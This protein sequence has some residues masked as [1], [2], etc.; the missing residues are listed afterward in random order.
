MALLGMPL[1]AEES[2]QCPEF[3]REYVEEVR[4]VEPE[5]CPELLACLTQA[6]VYHF[7]TYYM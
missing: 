4:K 2:E 6:Y 5:E 3:Y 1:S 7:S